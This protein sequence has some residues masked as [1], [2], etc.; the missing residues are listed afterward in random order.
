[1]LISCWTAARISAL[2]VLLTA[3]QGLSRYQRLR[4]SRSQ[5][6]RT[7]FWDGQGRHVCIYSSITGFDAALLARFPPHFDQTLVS[8][9]PPLALFTNEEWSH[10]AAK[11]GETKLELSRRKRRE[12]CSTLLRGLSICGRA[13]PL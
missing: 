8:S 12:G 7:K 13:M 9:S 6:M 11:R 1:M 5:E 3:G 4:R 10:G 2:F